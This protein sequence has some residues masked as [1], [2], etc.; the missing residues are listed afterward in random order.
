MLNKVGRWQ[1]SCL[2]GGG[3]QISILKGNYCSIIPQKF[4]PNCL[5]ISP[6]KIFNDFPHIFCFQQWWPS[7]LA[8]RAIKYNLKGDHPRTVSL[9]FSPYWP[10]SF[11]EKDFNDFWACFF[12][13]FSNGSHLGWRT[14]SLDI[15]L[16]WDH[17]RTI[18][19]KIGPNWPGV[20][21]EIKM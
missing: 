1:P 14:G 16:K 20:S 5:V 11:N 7:W 10:S 4:G 2:E 21:E 6:E 17:P 15:I 13:I 8:G 3:H 18:H 19:A 12:S 9:Q